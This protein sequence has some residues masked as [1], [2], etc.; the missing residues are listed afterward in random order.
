MGANECNA[1]VHYQ[2]QEG[3]RLFGCHVALIL[4]NL[5]RER[6]ILFSMFCLDEP[7]TK[8]Y[9]FAGAP[10]SPKVVPVFFSFQIQNSQ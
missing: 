7:N 3:L 5:P 6:D 10:W 1:W 2:G 9:R 4:Y 8:C